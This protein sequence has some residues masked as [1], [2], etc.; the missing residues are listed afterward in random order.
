MMTRF[1]HFLMRLAGCDICPVCHDCLH[2]CI[3]SMP[4]TVLF[5]A[6]RVIVNTAQTNSDRCMVD[7]CNDNFRVYCL[8]LRAK[9]TDDEDNPVRIEYAPRKL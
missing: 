8:P 6:L 4:S 1:V 3:S 5:D 7:V 9:M 2:E